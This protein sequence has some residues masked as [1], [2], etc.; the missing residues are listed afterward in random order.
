ML[1]AAKRLT[2]ITDSAYEI[3]I[4]NPDKPPLSLEEVRWRLAQFKGV[5]PV[6]LTAAPLF[7]DKVTLMPGCTFVVGY[8]TAKRILTPYYYGGKEEMI[9]RLQC[10]LTSDVKVV[11][12]G[13]VDAD[14]SFRT[15]NDLT[16]PDQLAEVFRQ[17]PEELFREDISSTQ[18]REQIAL[19]NAAKDSA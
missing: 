19:E 17:I 10:F 4:Y 7:T 8:D 12:A 15:L 6:V 13:R 3:T 18:I 2:G 1:E 5:S 14:S 16:I 9:A 11:V